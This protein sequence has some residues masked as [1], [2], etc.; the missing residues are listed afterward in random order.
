MIHKT[1]QTIKNILSG[2]SDLLVSA[3]EVIAAYHLFG[4]GNKVLLVVAII[5]AT[6]GFM[7][8][9]ARFTK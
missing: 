5:L 6:H 4:T 1:Q 7:V 3:S 9:L 2:L 8:A